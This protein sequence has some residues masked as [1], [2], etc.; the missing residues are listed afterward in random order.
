M[1]ALT[2]TISI[3]LY[4]AWVWLLW[5]AGLRQHAA[6]ELRLAIIT[7]HAWEA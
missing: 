3:G 4:S 6:H 7:G 5:R 1:D 2:I